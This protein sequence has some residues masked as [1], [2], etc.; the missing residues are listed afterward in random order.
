MSPKFGLN[1]DRISPPSSSAIIHPPPDFVLDLLSS[2]A[3]IFFFSFELNLLVGQHLQVPYNFLVVIASIR[4]A[5]ECA[6]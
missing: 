2:D 6:W 3:I 5:F 1:P 4:V